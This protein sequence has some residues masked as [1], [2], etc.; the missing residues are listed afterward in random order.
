MFT[1]R[2][3]AP[4]GVQHFSNKISYKY[5]KYVNMCEIC[6]FSFKTASNIKLILRDKYKRRIF[7]KRTLSAFDLNKRPNVEWPFIYYDN[8]YF[9][10]FNLI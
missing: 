3:L 8:E 10:S 5:Q 9:E 4:V 6:G 2:L 7:L 1:N